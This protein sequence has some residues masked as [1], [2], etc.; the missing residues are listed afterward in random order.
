M[1]TNIIGNGKFI[2]AMSAIK[3]VDIIPREMSIFESV[4]V[5]SGASSKSLLSQ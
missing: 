5:L 2:E 1:I 3:I 4:S